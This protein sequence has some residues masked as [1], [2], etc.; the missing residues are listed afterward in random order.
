MAMVTL[1]RPRVGAVFTW[2]AIW[3]YPVSLMYGTLPLDLRFDDL[4][5]MFI[6]FAT[7]LLFGDRRGFALG[8]VELLS[9]IWFFVALIGNVV[10]FLVLGAGSWQEILK[11]TGKAVYCTMH[12]YHAGNPGA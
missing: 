6:F 8:R 1:V 12:G 5:V 7:I 11:A 9:F 10:G 3:L 2:F 4:W